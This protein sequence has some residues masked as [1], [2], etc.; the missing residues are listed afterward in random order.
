MTQPQLCWSEWKGLA[1]LLRPVLLKGEQDSPLDY[2]PS[3][4]ALGVHMREPSRDSGTWGSNI[5][6][7]RSNCSSSP[8]NSVLTLNDSFLFVLFYKIRGREQLLKDTAFS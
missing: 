8:G 5:R 3:Q 1:S 4:V 2:P 6:A 7:I